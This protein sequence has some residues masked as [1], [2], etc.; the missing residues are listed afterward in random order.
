MHIDEKKK[1]DKR[2][3]ERNIKSGVITGKDYESYLSKLPDVSSKV[4]NPEEPLAE[5]E[6]SRTK[7]DAEGQSR[8]KA[9]K[10]KPKGKGK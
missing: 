10:K 2:N 1:L 6:E 5:P 8:K 4:F 7:K 9:E 3:V